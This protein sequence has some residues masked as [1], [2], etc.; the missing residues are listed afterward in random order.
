MKEKKEK[1][2]QMTRAMCLPVTI[3]RITSLLKAGK[4]TNNSHICICS[5]FL[6]CSIL[7]FRNLKK[8]S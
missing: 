5:Y 7:F 3:Y 2:L 4:W 6:I 1:S 8:I